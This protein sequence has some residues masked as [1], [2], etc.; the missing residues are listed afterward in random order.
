VVLDMATS[1]A[2]GGKLMLAEDKGIPIPI[3]WAL[4]KEG[5][6]T[7]N[8]KNVGALLPAGGPKGS[9]LAIMFECLSSIMAANPLQEPILTG[10]KKEKLHNQ[11]SVVAAIDIATFTDV[12]KYKETV[13]SYVD[14]IKAL[15]K[16]EGFSETL[17]P[18]EPEDRTFAERSKNGIPLPEGTVKNLRTMATRFEVKLP[19]GL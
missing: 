10:K 19:A 16:A 6:P 1:V 11:N 17:A 3:D 8:A 4:D 9:G 13:D 7:T 15:P 2:A 12:E 5:N 14:G 18:G